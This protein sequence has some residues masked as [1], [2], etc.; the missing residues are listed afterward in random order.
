MIVKNEECCLE[1][2][3]QSVQGLVDE[4]VVVDTG[5]TDRTV[6]VAQSFDAKIFSYQ[7]NDSF[8]DARN[9]SLD[10]ATG[11]WILVLDADEVVGLGDHQKIREL[12]SKTNIYLYDLIQTTYCEDSALLGWIPNKLKVAEAEGYLGYF[13]SP[14]VRLFRRKASIRFHGVLHEHASHCDS[15][16]IVGQTGLRIHHYGK[17]QDELL[18]EKK[19]DFYLS[20]AQKKVQEEP[21]NSLAWEELGVILLNKKL[22]A[23]AQ[24]SF[25]RALKLN[26]K[27]VQTH[28]SLATLAYH[29]KE[30][31]QAIHQYLDLL[32]M[33]PQEVTP[34]LFLP[35]L[36]SRVDQFEMAD[37]IIALGAGLAKDYPIFDLNCGIVEKNRG[38]FRKA[39]LLFDKIL[40]LSDNDK[41]NTI[42]KSAR[43]H[44]VFALMALNEHREAEILLSQVL[45]DPQMIEE[46]WEA[47]ILLE[48]QKK[49]YQRVL[50]ILDQALSSFPSQINFIYQKILVLSFLGCLE[51]ARNYYEENR[52]LFH[53]NKHVKMIECCLKFSQSEKECLLS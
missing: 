15:Q 29:R 47:Q 49:D 33:D 45:P 11:D 53:E 41:K 24:V 26:P 36:L 16:I 43:L 22:Y 31:N 14:L 20:L 12:I 10:Q 19:E 50:S 34:Y 32:M 40:N 3:L 46:L 1:R 27:S 25:E 18:R 17:I 35:A 44:K 39:I 37:K 2:C 48:L 23:E 5:S 28:V 51:E 38:N 13:E 30:W 4:I 42:K 21:Q 8:A 7:W 6:E 9:F 52:S